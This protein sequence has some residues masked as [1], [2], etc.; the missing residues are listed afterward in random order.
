MSEKHPYLTDEDLKLIEKVAEEESSAAAIRIYRQL[1]AKRGFYKDR[2]IKDY[3]WLAGY[4]KEQIDAA[5]KAI[6]APV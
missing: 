4:K 5:L 3:M 1:L 2:F 6:R